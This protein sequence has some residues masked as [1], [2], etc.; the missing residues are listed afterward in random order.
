MEGMLWPYLHSLPGTLTVYPKVHGLYLGVCVTFGY[1]HLTHVCCPAPQIED[2][3][4]AGSGAS[5]PLAATDPHTRPTVPFFSCVAR[6][7]LKRCFPDMSDHQPY[8]PD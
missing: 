3:V 2:D 1:G 6:F 7:E 8:R 5:R 4:Q